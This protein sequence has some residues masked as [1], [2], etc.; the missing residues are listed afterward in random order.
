VSR[1]LL[2]QLT[3]GLFLSDGGLETTLV[4]L[5]KI[6]LPHFA[7]FVLMDDEFGRERLERYY[8]PFLDI[9]AESPGA[10]FVLETPTWRANP[11]WANLLG[12]G[13][14]RLRDVNIAAAKMMRSL[15]KR[16]TTRIS[17][18]IVVSGIIGPRGDGDVATVPGSVED[19]AAYHTP[20]AE[21]LATGGVDMLTAVTMTTSVEALGVALAAQRVGLPVAVSFTVETDGRLP[22]GEQLGEAIQRV[23]ESASPAYFAINCA[24]P[25]HFV[26][27]LETAGPWATRVRGIRANASAKS[28]AELDESSE[29]D[30]GDPS[31]LA[32]RYCGLRSVLPNLNVLGGC[33]GTDW[34]H[35][36]ALRDAWI[37]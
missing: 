6:E 21:A 15:S 22:S 37:A 33:C 5:D 12:V 11:D 16:W 18:P 17:G 4:F 25:I 19:A 27:I 9:C 28:H 31:D 29:L 20:Q 1:F 36:R 10:G 2:P 30:I 24:H 13:A 34:R 32:Q 14:A 35:L 26:H 3:D 7:A 23:D 8:V